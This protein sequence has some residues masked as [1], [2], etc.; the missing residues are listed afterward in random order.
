MY[1]CQLTPWRDMLKNGLTTFAEN[2]DPTRS[3]CHAWS[4]SPNYDFLATICGI[5]PAAPGFRK[6]QIKPQLGELKQA[7][8][9]MPHPDGEIEVTLERR[10][11]QGVQAAITL[12]PGLSGTFLWNNTTRPLKA[13]KQVIIL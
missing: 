10:G 12:P 1:Y 11:E 3:D 4:A 9:R 7:S 5:T 8:G 6:V 13:G 2:P